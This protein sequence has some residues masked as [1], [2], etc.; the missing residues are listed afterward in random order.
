[1]SP[2]RLREESKPRTL[3]QSNRE[4]QTQQGHRQPGQASEN[5][6]PSCHR[7]SDIILMNEWV[8][9]IIY[10]TLIFNQTYNWKYGKSRI[11]PFR[12]ECEAMID[13][14]S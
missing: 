12:D 1:M 8:F 2:Y 10:Q 6:K 9:Y 13:R 7:V 14:L 11:L 4:K 5:L 3:V